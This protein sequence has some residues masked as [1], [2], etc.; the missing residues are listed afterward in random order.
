MLPGFDCDVFESLAKMFARFLA[1]ALCH[2]LRTFE[3]PIC[4]RSIFGLRQPMFIQALQP[5]PKQGFG[6]PRIV[7][8]QNPPQAVE[9]TRAQHRIE[10][11]TL[12]PNCGRINTL[13][14]ERTR[15]VGRLNRL[16]SGEPH[17]LFSI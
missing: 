8:G 1:T 15:N 11:S 7:N 16:L 4:L 17:R 12:R 3:L 6:S 5:I 9:S 2:E 10:S 14:A 13:I